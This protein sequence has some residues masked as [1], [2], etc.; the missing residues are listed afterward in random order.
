MAVSSN[1][2][3]LEQVLRLLKQDIDITILYNGNATILI[4]TIQYCDEVAYHST[5]KPKR[6]LQKTR[7]EILKL[8][9]INYNGL[10]LNPISYNSQFYW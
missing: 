8:L 5:T 7:R 3:S 9:E 1:I 6:N 2:T 10:K 4:D